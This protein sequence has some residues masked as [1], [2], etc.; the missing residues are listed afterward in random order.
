LTAVGRAHVELA[1]TVK[2][3]MLAEALAK[4]RLKMDFIDL[5][6]KHHVFGRFRN[7]DTGYLGTDYI[8]GSAI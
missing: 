1:P 7:D 5:N 8:K 2:M 6:N 3:M 4:A